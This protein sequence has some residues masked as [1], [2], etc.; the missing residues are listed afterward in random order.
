MFRAAE[1]IK[2]EMKEGPATRLRQQSHIGTRSFLDTFITNKVYQ[3]SYHRE[4]SE[5]MNF[6]KMLIALCPEHLLKT[7]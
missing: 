3:Y 5:R 1:E 2:E 4:I 7:Q 6:L